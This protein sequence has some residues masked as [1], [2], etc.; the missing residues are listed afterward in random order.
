MDMQTGMFAIT[1]VNMT[2]DLMNKLDEDSKQIDNCCRGFSA[3]TV[4]SAY[5][6]KVHGRKNTFI[7]LSF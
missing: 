2:L 1:F 6:F 4:T 7:R 5:V 3:A